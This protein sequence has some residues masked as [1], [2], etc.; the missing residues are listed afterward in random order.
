MVTAE[1]SAARRSLLERGHELWFDRGNQQ[2]GSV[3]ANPENLESPNKS[4]Q[5]PPAGKSEA[6]I[7][8]LGG[9]AIKGANK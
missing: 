4:E 8:S 7:K 3:V 6:T 1:P 5:K 2:E 9:T